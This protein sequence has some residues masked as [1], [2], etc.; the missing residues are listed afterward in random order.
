[1]ATKIDFKSLLTKLVTVFPKDIYIVHNWCVVAGSNSDSENRGSYFCILEPEARELLNKLFP[2]NPTLY[3]ESIRDTKT[4]ITKV[5]EILD[6]ST[7]NNV[8]TI[9]ESYMTEITGYTEWDTFNF[10]DDEINILFDDGGSLILFEN[11]EDKASIIISKSLF[12]LITNKTINDVKYVYDKYN[13]DTTLN[14][15]IMTYDHE[16]FQLVMKYLY[17][18]I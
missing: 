10:S 3:I 14:K 6:E 4:D 7:L 8:D 13:D 18:N 5:E 2:N 16:Y 17:L 12:P 11:D 9:V 1:M 15:I